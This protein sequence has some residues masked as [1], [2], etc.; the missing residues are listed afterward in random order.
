MLRVFW[1][2]A[3]TTSLTYAADSQIGPD[4]LQHPDVMMNISKSGDLN[5][6]VMLMLCWLVGCGTDFKK[7]PGW[8]PTSCGQIHQDQPGDWWM[9]RCNPLAVLKNDT[10]TILSCKPQANSRSTSAVPHKP[11]DAHQLASWC[12]HCLFADDACVAK[13]CCY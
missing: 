3:P 6:A 11:H 8:T 2:T 7:C 4:R 1:C 12:S 9:H 13:R 10:A 5:K